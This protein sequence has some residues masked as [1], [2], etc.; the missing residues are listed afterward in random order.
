MNDLI[1]KTKEMRKSQKEFFKTKN[2]QALNEA[3][4][5]EKEVDLILESYKACPSCNR[6]SF[7]DTQCQ[8]ACLFCFK[9]TPVDLI[10]GEMF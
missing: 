10:K 2:K 8:I 3:K 1:K 5:L 6:Y 7:Q 4:R 9:I